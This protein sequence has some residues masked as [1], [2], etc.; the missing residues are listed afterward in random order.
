MGGV[1]VESETELPERDGLKAPQP[2]WG[3]RV[4]SQ[5]ALR[6]TRRRT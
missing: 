4:R 2:R 5:R 1:I 6:F 3:S